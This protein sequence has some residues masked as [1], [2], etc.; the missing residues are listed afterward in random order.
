MESG[1]SDGS[2]QQ[3]QVFTHG[4]QLEDF[5]NDV[6]RCNKSRNKIANFSAVEKSS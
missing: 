2:W 3:Q 5:S 6:H 4:R 1:H